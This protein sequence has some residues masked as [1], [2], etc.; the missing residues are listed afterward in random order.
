MEEGKIA[1]LANSAEFIRKGD[2][3]LYP[4]DTIWGLGCDARNEAAVQRVLDIKGGRS[5]S[6]IVLVEAPERV[7]H[8][9]KEVPDPAWDLIETADKPTTVILP[10]AVGLAPNVPA[11]DG[12][13]GIRVVTEGF[14]H[15]LIKKTQKPLVSTSAN[16]SGEATPKNYGELD[17]ALIAD[18]DH[19]VDPEHEERSDPKPSSVIK[20]GMGGEVE[21]IRR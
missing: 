9:V 12:S 13:I 19:V 15:E 3:L 5:S 4:S 11:P 18:V 16:R 7:A 8:F 10:E 14:C 2:T 17:Q 21:I 1:E 20:I 6:L